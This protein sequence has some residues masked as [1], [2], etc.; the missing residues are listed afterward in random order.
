MRKAIFMMLLA[1]VSNS[2]MA[3]WIEVSSSESA[4][5]YADPASISRA[6]NLVQMW[7]LRDHKDTVRTSDGKPFVSAKMLREYDCKEEKSRVLYSSFHSEKMGEGEAVFSDSDPDKWM[8]IEPDSIGEDMWKIACGLSP[9]ATVH[10]KHDESR[11]GGTHNNESHSDENHIG[12]SPTHTSRTY[13]ATHRNS[14]HV[15]GV[16]RNLRGK[17][18]RSQQAKNNFK[19]R[20]P[21]PSTG[22]PSGA[23]P[24]YV[25]AYIKPLKYGGA[26]TPGNMRWQIKKTTR[27]K[28][29]V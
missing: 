5:N 8:Q 16:N 27:Q 28:K 17:I 29:Q 6:G 11:S 9:L 25:I 13:Q 15:Q 20:H 26:D 7:Y 12:N 23:C 10:K 22:K 19:H 21:C 14:K 18:T 24:G 3:K 4:T 2:A 1:I